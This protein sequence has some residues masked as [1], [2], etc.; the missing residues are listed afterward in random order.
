LWRVDII[1][2]PLATPVDSEFVVFILLGMI[3]IGSLVESKTKIPY[4]ITLIVIGIIVSFLVYLGII[5]NNFIDIRQFKFDPNLIVNFLIPPLIFEAMMQVDYYR[6]YKPVRIPVL[7][8]STVGVVITTIVVGFI[9][10]YVAHLPFALSFLFAALISSTDAAIVI[11]TFKRTRVPKM[12]A[13][14]LEMESSFNDAT[15]IILFSSVVVFVYGSNSPSFVTESLTAANNIFD[16]KDLNNLFGGL[17]YFLFVFFGGIFIGLIV[18]IIG[19][20]LHTLINDPFSDTALTIAGVFGAVTLANSLGVSGLIAVAIGGL[21][22]GNVTMK[23]ESTMSQDVRK[24]VSYFWQIAAFFANSIIFFYMGI[25][26]NIISISQNILLII[27]AFIVVLIARAASVYPI[28]SIVNKLGKKKIPSIWNNVIM[29]GGMRGAL[30]VALVTSLPAG[31]LKD[32]LEALT[33]GVVLASLIIQYI[34]LTK[35]IKK[36]TSSLSSDMEDKN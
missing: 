22:F 2:T 19:N 11:Q 6:E 4:T 29:I 12:L 23:R 28:L 18:A 8:F 31:E 32:K 3:F 17:V 30:A 10:I 20:R 14:I 26:M 1:S 36:K 27:L 15:T 13:R 7:L 33:F 9:M 25:T 35:Y 34:A 16:I 24:A 21:F 5:N